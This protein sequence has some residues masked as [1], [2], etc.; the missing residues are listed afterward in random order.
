MDSI[1]SHEANIFGETPETRRIP[2]QGSTFLL[3]F[4]DFCAPLLTKWCDETVKM[5][6]P[7]GNHET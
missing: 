4:D 3:A 1:H 5:T 2:L 7:P 6:V